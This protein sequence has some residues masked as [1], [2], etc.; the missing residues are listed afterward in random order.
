MKIKVSKVSVPQLSGFVKKMLLMDTSVYLNVNSE[1][2]WSDVYLPTKD[3]V[4]SFSLPCG[5]IFEFDKKL[6]GTIKFSFFSGAKLLSCLNY[7]DP[8]NLSAEISVFKDE[9]SDEDVYFAEKLILKDNQLKIEIYCQDISYGF[10]SMTPAQVERAYDLSTNKFSFQLSSENLSKIGSFA[11]LDKSELFSIY[12]DKSGVHLKTETLDF[13][14]DDHYNKDEDEFQ[15][16]KS[17]L[18]RVDKETY[19]VDVC[20]NK[21]ILTST[22]SET[23]IAINLAITA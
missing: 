11:T 7:F 9:D 5:E 3:V 10:T 15:L 8:H 12:S 17:F 22:Q 20:S 2:V 18:S 6:E 13:I 21:I 4:K 14:I 1:K 16:F 19:D 23:K